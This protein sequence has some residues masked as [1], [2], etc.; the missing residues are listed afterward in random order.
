MLFADRYDASLKLILLLEKFKNDNCVIL[1]VPRGGV[2]IG[3][4]IAQAYHFPMDLLL[5]KKIGHPLNKELA[6]GAVSLEDEIIDDYPYI[7]KD[8]INNQILEIKESL[9]KRYKKFLGNRSPIELLN[10]TVIIVDDGIATGNTL[11]AAIKMIRR[12]SPKKIVIA[13]PVAPTDSA[14]KIMSKVDEFICPLI[15]NDFVGVGGYYLD[16]S[17]VSDEEVIQLMDEIYS[18]ENKK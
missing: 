16:F 10:K 4:H 2:P 5:T 17:Q 12:K 8:Y 6:I 7:S 14:K 18:L 13:V 11:L 9:K 3:Y 1:A 15:T